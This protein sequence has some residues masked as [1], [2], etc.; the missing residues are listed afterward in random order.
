MLF[1]MLA[2]YTWMPVFQQ[3]LRRTSWLAWPLALFQGLLIP[4][5]MTPFMYWGLWRSRD[6]TAKAIILTGHCATCGYVL[7]GVQPESDGCTVC[8]ECGSAWRLNGG[9]NARPCTSPTIA[10][11]RSD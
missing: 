5:S 1:V 11:S 3:L 8:P 10:G 7:D 9:K 6:H 4:I 2:M